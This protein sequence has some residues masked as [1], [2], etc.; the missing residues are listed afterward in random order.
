[1]TLMT[2][3]VISNTLQPI[4]KRADNQNFEAFGYATHFIQQGYLV[5]IDQIG[6]FFVGMKPLDVDPIKIDYDQIKTLQE[7][8]A[9]F[10]GPRRFEFL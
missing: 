8:M 1:M 10:A 3:D 9:V 7:K 4:L 5:K 2:K 6:N